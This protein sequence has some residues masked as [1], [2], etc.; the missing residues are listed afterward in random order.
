LPKLPEQTDPRQIDTHQRALAALIQ[1]QRK[2]AKQG[3]LLTPAMQQRIRA[4]LRPVFTGEDGRQIKAEILDKEYKGNVKLAINGRYPDEVPISTV[5]T[6]VLLA[7]PK[8]PGELEY[9]FIQN[10]LIL[11]DPHA[12]I[13]ADYMDRAFI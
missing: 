7:L 4:L 11:F 8:L 3:D 2:A 6:Q 5:P 10:N 1:A 13:I 9:R 12:H